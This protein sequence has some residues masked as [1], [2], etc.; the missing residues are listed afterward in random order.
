MQHRMH[1]VQRHFW[2]RLV[3]QPW[4]ERCVVWLAGVRRVGRPSS[5]LS[6][7]SQDNHPGY[8]SAKRPYELSCTDPEMVNAFSGQ[9]DLAC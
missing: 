1:M 9:F 7:S 8:P 2:Q 3:E 4:R 5:D 6:H